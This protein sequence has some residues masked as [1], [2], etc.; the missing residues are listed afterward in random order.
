MKHDVS[1]PT[2]VEKQIEIPVVDVFVD[3]FRERRNVHDTVPPTR[4]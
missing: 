2:A 3:S 1:I 4:L